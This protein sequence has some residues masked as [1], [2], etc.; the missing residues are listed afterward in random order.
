MKKF[1]VRGLNRM[2]NV[3][4]LAYD[5]AETAKMLGISKSL[6]YREIQNGKCQLPYYRIGGRIIFPIKKLKDFLNN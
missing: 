6:L 2:E 1:L 4:K 3:E 5:V